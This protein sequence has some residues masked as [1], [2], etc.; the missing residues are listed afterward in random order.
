METLS[1]VLAA[2]KPKCRERQW[3]SNKQAPREKVPTNIS[4]AIDRAYKI[5]GSRGQGQGLSAFFQ[6]T[7]GASGVG[8]ELM[9]R[10][11]ADVL[12]VPR[13]DVVEKHVEQHNDILTRRKLCER[14]TYQT[15]C[16]T[17]TTHTR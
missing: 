3:V 14:Y 16:T 12:Q 11:E 9:L 17:I 5:A 6:V 13:G 2:K 15:T 1:N 8:H 7:V 10:G 4:A